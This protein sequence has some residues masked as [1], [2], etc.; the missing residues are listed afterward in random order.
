MIQAL[1]SMDPKQVVFNS[2]FGLRVSAMPNFD[3]QIN[4]ECKP[5]SFVVDDRNFCIASEYVSE[6]SQ[7]KNLLFSAYRYK[8]FCHVW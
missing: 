8:L 4:L 3:D 6:F 2:K 5:I 7:A 1:L